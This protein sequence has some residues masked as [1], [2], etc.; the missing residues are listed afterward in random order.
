[1]LFKLLPRQENGKFADPHDVPGRY[2][3]APVFSN[4]AIEHPWKGQWENQ[5]Q[6]VDFPASH[7]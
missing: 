3:Y 4:V 2:S 6:M 7:V 1:L 5:L